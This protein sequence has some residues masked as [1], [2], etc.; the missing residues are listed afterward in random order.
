MKESV[1]DRL[2][3]NAIFFVALGAVLV[4][5]ISAYFEPETLPKWQV[6]GFKQITGKP[7]PGCGMTRAFC[8]ISHARLGDAYHLNPFSFIF[9]SGA[10]ILALW[11]LLSWK[12][13]KV[14]HWVE[15]TNLL[16]YILPGILV[17]MLVFG[18]VRMV[19]GPNV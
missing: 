10:L 14:N 13:P 1:I 18:A 7:C 3:K 12:F 19:V 5:A 16:L 2:L 6:C 11:P 15:N 4:L 17:A 8:A 9:Y